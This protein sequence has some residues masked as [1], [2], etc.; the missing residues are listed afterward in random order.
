MSLN[1]LKYT[2]KLALNYR[3]SYIKIYTIMILIQ[4]WKFPQI[5]L[6]KTAEH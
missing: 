2:G 1:V 5:L 4:N 3:I 6:I